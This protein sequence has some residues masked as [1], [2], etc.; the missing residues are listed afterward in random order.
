M[1]I[2]ILNVVE[3]LGKKVENIVDDCVSSPQWYKNT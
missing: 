2:K 3:C 1:S